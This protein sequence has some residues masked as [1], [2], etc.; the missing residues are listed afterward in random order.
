M[1]PMAEPDGTPA[2]DD[3]ALARRAVDGAPVIIMTVD[4]TGQI[5]WLSGALER[6]T[7]YRIDEL[8][9]TN[10]LDHID[11]DW[12]PAALE[13]VGFA[14]TRSGLQRPMMFKVRRKDGSTFIAEATANA[15]VDDPLVGGLI[16]YIRRFDER[17]L[18]D[19]VIEQLASGAP[20]DQTLRVLIEVM[21]AETLDGVGAVLLEPFAGRFFR[22]VAA[23]S[24]P[25]ALAE[26]DGA[27]R[28]PWR[29]AVITGEPQAVVVA[30]L[31]DPQ[32][33]IAAAAGFA[34]CWVWPVPRA[35]QVQAC[36]V[37][38]R[39]DEEEPDYT[40]RWLLDN[41]VRV[42]GLVLER[43]HQAE[44]LRHAAS[45]DALTGLANRGRFFDHLRVVLGD[46]RAGPLVGVLYID[47]DD[48]KPVNDRLGHGAGDQLL[49]EVSRRLLDAVRE[50]DLVARLGG[51]EFAIVCSGAPDVEAL[52]AVAKRVSTSVSAPIRVGREEVSVGASVGIAGVAPGSCTVDELVEAADAALYAAKRSGRG[53]WRVADGPA[54]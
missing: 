18:L 27:R 29:Q 28:T 39:R 46:D 48:F 47:L 34:A 17:H 40:C 1:S 49:G 5:T 22:A 30:E 53:G 50:G 12:N 31:P 13:S 14:F 51:D 36:L 9:G 41:L 2:V 19:R 7:G 33:E 54:R 42:T 4:P 15:Q 23:P 45:H 37:L 6:L 25:A 35:G 10:F 20:I 3:T 11:A 38:W 32:Q 26:D 16:A 44:R 21:G 8:V 43:D 52:I 24:L